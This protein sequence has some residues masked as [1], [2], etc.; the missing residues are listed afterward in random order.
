MLQSFQVHTCTKQLLLPDTS[1]HDFPFMW[2]KQFICWEAFPN[3]FQTSC[4]RITWM[5]A[6]Y[7]R[8][9]RFNITQHKIN[10]ANHYIYKGEDK[11]SYHFQLLL[12]SLNSLTH[13]ES[14]P[15]GHFWELWIMFN[16]VLSWSAPW[17][18][19]TITLKKDCG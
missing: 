6:F 17:L 7:H 9:V 19:W 13:L 8:I 1:T 14:S 10:P 11:I 16:F 12:D 15:H 3:K 18:I 5:K 4:T 2:Y